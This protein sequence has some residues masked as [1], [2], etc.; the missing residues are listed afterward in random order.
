MF[1]HIKG[2]EKQNA[3]LN[4]PAGQAPIIHDDIHVTNSNIPQ[5]KSN[6]RLKDVGAKLAQNIGL[7]RMILSISQLSVSIIY[8]IIHNS[9]VYTRMILKEDD[10]DGYTSSSSVF[11]FFFFYKQLVTSH[12]K[13]W[14]AKT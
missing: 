5:V 10:K 9:S 11:H 2:I 3:S 1:C 12:L 4:I 6:K 13:R 7:K 14:I 8:Y